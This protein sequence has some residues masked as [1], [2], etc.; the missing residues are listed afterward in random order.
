VVGKRANGEGSIYQR[1]DGRWS[2]SLSIGRGRRKHFLGHSRADVAAKLSQALADQSKGVPV[3]SSNRSVGQYLDY[4]LASVKNSV[5]PKTHESYDLNVRRLKPLL[6]KKRL[7]ALAPAAIES[8]YGDLQAEGLARRSVVQAHTVLHNSLKKAVQWGL[9][10]RN[11][12]DGASVPRPERNEMQTLDEGQVRQLFTSTADEPLHNLWVLLTTT[13]LRLGEALGLKW[14]DVDFAHG[15]LQVRRALQRQTGKGL[16]IV[17]PKTSKSRRTVYFPEGTAEAL[18]QQRL[19]VLKWKHDYESDWNDG[20]LVFCREDG[21]PL[22]PTGI[23]HKLKRALK[24]AGLPAIRVH[25][26]RHTAAS[27]HLARGENPKVVQELLGHSTITITLDT[28][29]H[30]TPGIH[31]AAAKKMQ[32]L[33]T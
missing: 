9:I 17:E 19:L 12:A 4:W 15:R 11:P 2:A 10:G 18:R 22:D 1:K 26:L 20:G 29:S 7:S 33:F 28:Y 31:A 23:S 21:Q 30:V 25:D 14:E 5:R 27:L 32:G 13:G 16:V 6:G 24:R 8:A 3:I